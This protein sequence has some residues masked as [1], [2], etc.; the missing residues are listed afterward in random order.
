PTDRSYRALLRVPSLGRILLGMAF[1]RVAQAMVAIALVLFTLAE[2]HSPE[3][4]GLVTFASVFPGIA[5]SPIAGVL[6]DRH[7]RIRLMIL[8]YVVAAAALAL[9]AGLASAHALPAWLL[10]LIAVVMSL[11]SIFSS[12]G[13]RTLFPLI[14]PRHLWERANALDSNGYVVATIFGPPIAA[15][16]VAFGGGPVALFA[17]G[18]IYGLTA[19][20]MVGVQDPPT[21]VTATGTL[22]SDARA[23]LVYV[24]RNRTLRG[25]GISVSVLNLTGGMTTIV[26]PLLVLR[27]LGANEALVGILFAI[28]GV[29]GMIS[30]LVFGR[31]DTRGREWVMLVLPPFGYAAAIA[32]V[33]PVALAG[34]IG[35]PGALE[36][37][38]GIG[39]IA[40]AQ[41]LVGLVNGPLDIAL[42]TVRQRRTDPAWLG[43]AFAIS[44]G[45]NFVGYPIGAALTGVIAASSLGGAVVLGIGAC[46]ASGVLAAVL[47]PVRD[48]ATEPAV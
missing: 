28:S 2:Y 10:V 46:L 34:P 24:W 13:L 8:D 41:L 44:M 16:L 1:A 36:P 42:F 26:V 20:S 17:I 18:V 12:V 4:A 38:L 15:S 31:I 40:A 14:V 9:V 35:T 5:I 23:G 48:P 19:V 37:A 22:L 7:G 27:Q 39:L 21:T 47:I 43:R 6:L 25:L 45:F 11:T 32:L 33:L 3:L 30:A 29:S